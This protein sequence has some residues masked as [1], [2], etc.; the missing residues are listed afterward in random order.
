MFCDAQSWYAENIMESNNEWINCQFEV[1]LNEF[2]IVLGDRRSN[3][4]AYFDNIQVGSGSGTFCGPGVNIEDK[5]SPGQ[6]GRSREIVEELATLLTAGR[7]SDT[8]RLIIRDAYDRAGSGNDG[9]RIAQ[10]MILTSAEFHATNPV[11]PQ[12]LSRSVYSFPTSTGKPYK[13]LIYVMF[14]GGCDSFNM[15]VPHTCSAI[16]DLYQGY[17]DI[18]EQVAIAKSDLLPINATNQ[19]CTK[20]GLHPDLPAIQKMYNDGDLLF[21]ANTGVMTQV[22]L[23]YF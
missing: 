10:E 7:L 5:T 18:R 16:N 13:A 23:F 8:S 17:L 2:R 14:S 11:N 12:E 1:P 15:L 3:G 20:Y 21:F 6:L 22:R 4:D 19:N 9:L